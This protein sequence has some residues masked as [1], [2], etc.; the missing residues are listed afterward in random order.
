MYI[1]QNRLAYKSLL[2]KSKINIKHAHFIIIKNVWPSISVH[3][4]TKKTKL[5]NSKPINDK[6]FHKLI[7]TKFNKNPK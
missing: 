6:K 3:Q 2:N 5:I 4:F 7:S 1:Q